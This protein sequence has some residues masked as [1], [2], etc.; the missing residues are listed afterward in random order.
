VSE[1]RRRYSQADWLA[2]QEISKHY[3]PKMGGNCRSVWLAMETLAW[4][5]RKKHHGRAFVTS[6][7]N[8]ARV[9]CMGKTTL[10]T[11][12]AFLEEI[13]LVTITHR[14]T[15]ACRM[16]FNHYALRYPPSMA[17]ERLRSHSRVSDEVSRLV[18]LEKGEAAIS[19]AAAAAFP[20]ALQDIAASL[21]EDKPEAVVRM[22]TKLKKI[23]GVNRNTQDNFKANNPDQIRALRD[24]LSREGR[25]C[26]FK[27]L[28]E[29]EKIHEP[30]AG[31]VIYAF[32]K[33]G[34]D[35]E[36]FMQAWYLTYCLMKE[37][38]KFLDG[39]WRDVY[40]ENK[41]EVLEWMDAMG[42]D[43]G[44]RWKE[45]RDVL[46]AANPLPIAPK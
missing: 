40:P 6:Q 9:A 15:S 45:Q 22:A 5:Q 14:R 35:D 11:V 13:D 10:K 4:E 37:D 39:A 19:T 16:D 20:L 1:E 36:I 26:M 17:D 3:P 29:M 43:I 27:A 30:M 31:A 18:L 34:E 42:G 33:D 8:L 12:C 2:L 25:R 46:L 7:N 21:Y 24:S 38:M 28:L 41:Q 32:R 23:A 44:K